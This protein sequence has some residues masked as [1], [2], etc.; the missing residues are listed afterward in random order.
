MLTVEQ[1]NRIMM[2]VTLE[3]PETLMTQEA[4]LFR[5]QVTKEI[6]EIKR[7]GQIILFPGE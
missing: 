4:I 5:V 6:A 7:N 3:M 1:M 2:E